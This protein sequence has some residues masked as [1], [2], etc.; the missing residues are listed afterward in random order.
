MFYAK[1]EQTK[2]DYSSMNKKNLKELC[3]KRG[4][5]NSENEDELRNLLEKT[6]LASYSLGRHTNR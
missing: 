2:P 1:E 4:L 5:E 3:K 6:R